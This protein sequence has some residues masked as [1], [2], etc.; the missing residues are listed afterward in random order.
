VKTTI[1]AFDHDQRAQPMSQHMPESFLAG[2]PSPFHIKAGNSS[3][4]WLIVMFESDL[5]RILLTL[6]IS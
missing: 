2:D 6:S 4:H 3:T 1:A 5:F